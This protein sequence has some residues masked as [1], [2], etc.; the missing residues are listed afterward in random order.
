LNLSRSGNGD[1][2]YRRQILDKDANVSAA[3]ALAAITPGHI[4][5]TMAASGERG[6]K[7]PKRESSPIP[8]LAVSLFLFLIVAA[9]VCLELVRVLLMPQAS[10]KR[11]QR[12][13][14]WGFAFGFAAGRVLHPVSF[15]L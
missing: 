5:T 7:I 14:S 9:E 2:I 8:A 10:A 11:S 6:F 4:T 3:A 12:Y 13:S 15:I 1:A